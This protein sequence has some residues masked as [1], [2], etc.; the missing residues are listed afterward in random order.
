M[1]GGG[2]ERQKLARKTV[3]EKQERKSGTESG[4]FCGYRFA[5][6]TCPAKCKLAWQSFLNSSGTYLNGSHTSSQQL[7]AELKKPLHGCV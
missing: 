2:S 3:D 6:Q 7:F 4:S 5:I 1:G